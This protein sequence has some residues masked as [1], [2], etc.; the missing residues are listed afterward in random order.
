MLNMFTTRPVD[1]RKDL[2]CH[3]ELTRS[4][5]SFPRRGDGQVAGRIFRAL[6]DAALALIGSCR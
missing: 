6:G 4:D 2:E 5:D 3:R 1:R